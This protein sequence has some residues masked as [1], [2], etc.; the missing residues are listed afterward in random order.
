MLEPL[1]RPRDRLGRAPA[2]YPAGILA[3]N[4]I[5]DWVAE[6]PKGRG[7][8]GQKVLVESTE[9]AHNRRLVSKG[10]SGPVGSTSA[11]GERPRLSEDVVR[12]HTT[13]DR[14]EG[15]FY[16]ETPGGV[17]TNRFTNGPTSV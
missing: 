1:A 9:A 14:V 8:R 15:R 10:H 12:G 7:G 6:S 11:Q 17:T 2:G 16:E 5:E 3:T 4:L 13:L